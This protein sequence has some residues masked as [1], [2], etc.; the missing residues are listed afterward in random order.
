MHTHQS[1][2]NMKCARRSNSPQPQERCERCKKPNGGFVSIGARNYYERQWAEMVR[3]G[4]TNLTERC[5]CY[6]DEKLIKSRLAGGPS[7]DIDIEFLEQNEDDRRFWKER[8]RAEE[9]AQRQADDDNE[10]A[11]EIE[12]EEGQQRRKK[13]RERSEARR[14]KG[15][16]KRS[17]NKK[18][19]KRPQPWAV[20]KYSVRSGDQQRPIMPWNAAH[21]AWREERE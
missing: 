21:A 4:T 17:K 1:K 3:Q 13:R 16:R 11:R 8:R 15:P 9:K 12:F 6:R 19:I 5:E 14:D 20:T 10:A 7:K 2:T 18:R